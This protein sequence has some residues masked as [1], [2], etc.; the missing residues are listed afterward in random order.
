[1]RSSLA[2]RVVLVSRPSMSQ[3]PPELSLS[4][5]SIAFASSPASSGSAPLRIS[6][7]GVKIA[8]NEKFATKP[9]EASKGVTMKHRWMRGLLLVCVLLVYTSWA[10]YAGR[11]LGARRGQTMSTRAVQAEG[12][13]LRGIGKDGARR[14]IYAVFNDGSIH[15]YDIDSGH[16]EIQSFRTVEGVADVRGVCASAVT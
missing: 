13:V 10:E 16:R 6:S 1:M 2:A 9:L 11:H 5:R 8:S 4:E 3:D 15:A 14:Y 12:G 7:T